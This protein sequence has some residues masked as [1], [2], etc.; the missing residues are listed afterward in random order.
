MIPG[1]FSRLVNSVLAACVICL[2]CYYSPKL[3][4]RQKI[5][6]CMQPPVVKY[7]AKR[8]TQVTKN[9]FCKM[10][11][12]IEKKVDNWNKIPWFFHFLMDF[13]P[14]GYETSH[15]HPRCAPWGSVGQANK[16]SPRFYPGQTSAA[17]PRYLNSSEISTLFCPNVL[18]NVLQ[19]FLIG[20][21]TCF[22]LFAFSYK[23]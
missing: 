11:S 7:Q 23:N 3:S 16:T 4:L 9:K 14:Y 1:Y 12:D 2:N 10:Y 8:E 5:W 13:H 18:N 6:A 22:H 21:W 17:C 19:N 20:Q 15:F